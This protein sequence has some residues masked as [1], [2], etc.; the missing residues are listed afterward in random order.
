MSDCFEV[1]CVQYVGQGWRDRLQ[2]DGSAEVL[3]MINFPGQKSLGIF[4]TV[5]SS[6]AAIPHGLWA[7]VLDHLPKG[8][9]YPGTCQKENSCG[10]V[11]VCALKIWEFFFC[12]L[13]SFSRMVYVAAVFSAHL[14]EWEVIFGAFQPLPGTMEG[15]DQVLSLPEL[16]YLIS[17]G[18][19]CPFSPYPFVWCP[20]PAC[21]AKP[22]MLMG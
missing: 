3:R 10:L 7:Q 13:G 9:I 2:I 20:A 15:V 1:L 12:I 21:I 4:F 17:C 6:Q 22:E 5:S 14:H 19:L 18:K 8:E 16:Q 11:S